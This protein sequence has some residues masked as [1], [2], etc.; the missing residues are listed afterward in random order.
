MGAWGVGRGRRG[1]V[2]STGPRGR[3]AG[4]VVLPL[5]GEREDSHGLWSPAGA[6]DGGVREAASPGWAG[7]RPALPTRGQISRE[8][9]RPGKRDQ[10]G[11]VSCGEGRPPPLGASR[12]PCLTLPPERCGPR[13]PARCGGPGRGDCIVPPT[14]RSGGVQPPLSPPPRLHTPSLA[15]P[16]SQEP[17]HREG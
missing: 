7:L 3:Q 9:I 6:C 2:R 15:R 4:T 16:A 8:S 10:G 1:C 14:P 17:P 11:R 13:S 5:L 12:S